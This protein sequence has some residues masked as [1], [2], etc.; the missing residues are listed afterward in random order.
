MQI[1]CPAE[2]A[3]GDDWNQSPPLPGVV[4]LDSAGL[5]W[6]DVQVLRVRDPCLCDG[7]DIVAPGHQSIVLI[8]AAAEPIGAA[9]IERRRGSGWLGARYRA[10]D[11]GFT[12]PGEGATLRWRNRT[13]HT[14]VQVRL[15]A[16]LIEDAAEAMG[17]TVPAVR[18]NRLSHRDPTLGAL[19]LA[20]ERAAEQ[21]A[22]TF[23]AGAAAHFLA[24]HLVGMPD[25]PQPE[26]ARGRSLALERMDAFLRARLADDVTLAEL[27]D[28]VGTSPFR[29]IRL[30]SAHHGETPFRRLQRFRIEHARRLLQARGLSITEIALECGYA[31]PSAFGCAFLRATGLS[32][33]AY[34]A[35]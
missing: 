24:A 8:K 30:C 27:A 33:S 25:A 16:R 35:L 12:A 21:Q 13:E 15:R 5:G 17:L 1:T 28:H 18:L 9:N 14:S 31:S 10:G 6:R 2:T 29:L 19:V 3:C 23:Y 4:E 7:V 32:P 11:L 34:R 22:S 26:R 20:L